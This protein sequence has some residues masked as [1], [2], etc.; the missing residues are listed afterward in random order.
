MQNLN[1][2][3]IK[4]PTIDTSNWSL[5]VVALDSHWLALV[6]LASRFFKYHCM[7]GSFACFLLSADLF[8]QNQHVRK[9]I[10]GIPSDC[11]TV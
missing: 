10:S 9:I 5:S 4:F 6:D 7:L 2:T 3:K 1:A 11:Q 8:F